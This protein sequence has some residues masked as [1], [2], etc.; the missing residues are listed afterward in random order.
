[1]HRIGRML[2]VLVPLFLVAHP[3][4]AQGR[5][6]QSSGIAQ[7]APKIEAAVDY[8]YVRGSTVSTAGCCFNM[9]GGTA[10]VA[11]NLNEWL[12][13]VG[14]GGG[15]YKSNLLNS[16]LSLSVFSYM[17]GPR[18]S[19]RKNAR[20]TPFIEGLFGGGHA[21]GTLYTRA[22]QPG[23][24]PPTARNAFAM[25]L[26]G[27]LDINLSPHIA[28]RAFQADW[29]YTQFPNGGNNQ[30]NNLRITSGLVLRWGQ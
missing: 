8:A 9:N 4:G 16:G 26:G 23:G 30:Q 13:L 12:G 18:V 24:A 19:I 17:F 15:Y 1:M 2:A 6:P 14:E 5:A 28:V 3:A 7:D 27:G 21:G 25:A 29:L 20:V 11:L 22:F 10:S